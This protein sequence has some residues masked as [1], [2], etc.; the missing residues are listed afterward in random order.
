MKKLTLIFSLLIFF[1]CTKDQDKVQS[2]DLIINFTNT[3]AGT[4]LVMYPFGCL[5]GGNCIPGHACCMGGLNY[6]IT[7]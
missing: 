4:D 6:I 1:G 2:S 3:V 5:A 7:V